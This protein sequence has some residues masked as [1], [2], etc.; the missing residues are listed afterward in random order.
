[1]AT[2]RG[3]TRLFS[4][5]FGFSSCYEQISWTFTFLEDMQDREVSALLGLWSTYFSVLAISLPVT[6]DLHT[7][8][9]VDLYNN[10]YH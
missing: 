5:S 7:E 9:N 3:R 2:V 4:P 8:E 1:M 6:H 10:F